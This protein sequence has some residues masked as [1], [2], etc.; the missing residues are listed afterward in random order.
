MQNKVSTFDYDIIKGWYE[1][2]IC[3]ETSGP[4]FADRQF[5]Y[6]PTT[7]PHRLPSLTHPQLV[8]IGQPKC[9]MGCISESTMETYEIYFLTVLQVVTCIDRN[10]SIGWPPQ[11]GQLRDGFYGQC[12]CDKNGLSAKYP[13]ANGL[14]GLC[15]RLLVF[16]RR[17]L[18][19]IQF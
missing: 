15:I 8:S 18:P 4:L 17:N 19:N 2:S 5:S 3:Q 1:P 13:S 16:E 12:A 14:S 7:S 6:V 9:V 11:N 10:V